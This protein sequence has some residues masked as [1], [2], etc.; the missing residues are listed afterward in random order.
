MDFKQG[1][2]ENILMNAIWDMEEEGFDEIDVSEVQSRINSD[3][4]SWA[5]TTIKTVLD[6]LVKKD[7]LER[8]KYN[9]KFFYKSRISRREAGICA[10][11]KVAKQYFKGEMTDLIR[12]ADRIC[13]EILVYR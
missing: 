8:I 13:S 3:D 6:R 9:K 2:F 4:Q 10:I 7:T 1:D 12:A 11:E 5:Y